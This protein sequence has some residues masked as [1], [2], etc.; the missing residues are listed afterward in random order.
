MVPV[1]RDT[2]NEVIGASLESVE[3]PA[4]SSVYIRKSVFPLKIK[5]KHGRP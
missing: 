1:L 3:V 4:R 2:T 5:E